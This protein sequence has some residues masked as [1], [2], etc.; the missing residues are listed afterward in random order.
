MKEIILKVKGMSCSGC[1]KRIE[2]ALQELKG[3]NLVKANYIKEEVKITL[4]EDIKISTLK[5]I[6]EELDFEVIE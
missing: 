5:Q 2:N 3:V 6:I 4:K 1:E